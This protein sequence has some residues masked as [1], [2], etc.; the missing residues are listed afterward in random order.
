MSQERKSYVYAHRK[1]SNGEVFYIGKG[2]KSR[3]RAKCS[4]T[5][6]WHM[7]VAKHGLI[8]E[9]ILGPMHEQC[10]FSLERMLIHSIGL[11]ALCNISTG[12]DGGMTGY[13]FDRKTVTQKAKKCMKPVVNSDGEFFNSLKEA[14][15]SMRAHGYHRATESHISN[16]CNGKRHVAYGRSWS[17]GAVAPSLIDAKSK[18]NERRLR[19]VKSSN[20]MIFNSVSEAASWVRYSIGVKCGT[21]DIS[22][23]CNGKR[24]FCAG[25]KWE[26][27]A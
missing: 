26:Y 15:E 12:G 24:S 4:R 19:A 17:F 9:E 21:S 22:R 6:R 3:S 14:A 13:K 27:V 20:G 1:A 2:Q 18:V 7:T 23:C 5:R 10:A 8:I 25:L 11:D 16:C